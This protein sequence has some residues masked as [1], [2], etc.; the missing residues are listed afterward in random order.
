MKL[1]LYILFIILIFTKC[2]SQI[3]KENNNTLIDSLNVKLNES[4][5]P[6]VS[7]QIKFDK[8]S[9]KYGNN[10]LLSLFIKNNQNYKQKLLIDKPIKPWA[11]SA[12]IFDTKTNNSVLEFENKALLSSTAYS[13]KELNKYYYILEP[14]QEKKIRLELKDI[15]IFNTLDNNLK[16]GNYN[17]RLYYYDNNSNEVNFTIY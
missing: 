13:E 14:N 16:K 5:E 4:K 6:I 3:K 7:I 17:I 2:N 15:V 9:I 11:I 12:K 1:I 10:I 8:N